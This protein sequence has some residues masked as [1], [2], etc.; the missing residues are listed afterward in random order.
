MT[1]RS[2]GQLGLRINVI[3]PLVGAVLATAM[4]ARAQEALKMEDAIRMALQN[5]ERALK[6][7][8]RVETAE[9]QLDRSRTAFYPTLTAG[10]SSTWNATEDRSGRSITTTGTVTLTQPLLNPSAFPLYAQSRHQLES[11]KWGAYQDRRVLAFDTARAYL[12]VLTAEKVLDAAQKR[13]D[14]AKT[15]IAQTQARADAG[16]VS[17]NDVT[18]AQVEL[19]TSLRQVATGDGSA[20][21]A[22]TNLNFLVNKKIDQPLVEPNATTNNA[23]KFDKTP[24][25]RLKAA[26]DRRPDV[27]SAAE[28]T[29]ALELSAAEPLY[30]LIPSLNAQGQIRLIPDPL[31]TEQG[32]TET[33]GLNLTWNIFDQ[34]AR[35]A[36]RKTRLAQAES[37]ALDEKALRRSVA[38]DVELAVISLRSA[39]E[40]FR[41]AGDAVIAATKLADQTDILYKQGLA[42]ALEVTDAIGQRYDAEVSAAS[43]KLSMESAYLE[44]RFALGLGPI[45]EDLPK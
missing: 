26:V 40:T 14:T 30:R 29:R 2:V 18:R 33:V 19:A 4:P 34:G 1:S 11:E 36:D 23:Q 28:R 7:P 44:L 43:A 27:K 32:A 42:S 20:K 16:L 22:H 10:G 31:A 25:E 45:D 39:R 9:G 15:N 3:G 37:Q 8:Y 21:R 5:N 24:E 12:T 38:N 41:I 6:A 13:V 35:Y 17:T